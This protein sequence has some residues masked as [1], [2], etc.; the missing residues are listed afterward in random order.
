[1]IVVTGN[2]YKF[3]HIKEFFPEAEQREIDLVEIQSLDASEIIRHKLTEARQN[4]SGEIL[5]EDTSLLC[6][7]LQG[8]PGPLV[9]FFLQTVRC[10]GIWHMSQSSGN[11]QAQAVTTLGYL[12]ETGEMIITQGITTGQ[13]VAPRGEG[14]GWNPIFQPDGADQTYAEMSQSEHRHWNMRLKA[15]QELQKQLSDLE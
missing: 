1:M 9:K 6:D 4:V 8:L 2:A 5:V 15:L 3:G 13:I 10:E 14:H 7:G 12:S 11:T